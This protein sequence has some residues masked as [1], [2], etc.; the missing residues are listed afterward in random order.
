MLRDCFEDDFGSF[1]SDTVLKTERG[2]ALGFQVGVAL[3]VLLLAGSGRVRFAVKFYG[4]LQL[5]AVEIEDVIAELVLAT[6]FQVAALPVTQQ[7]PEQFFG[8]S[9]F[10]SQFT[11]PFFQP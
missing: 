9:L 10:L 1:D 2:H 4:K 3:G 5:M 11:R 8:G 7:F 6:E